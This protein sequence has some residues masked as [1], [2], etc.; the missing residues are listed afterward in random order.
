MSSTFNPQ[1]K[2]IGEILNH[3]VVIPSVA[4]I[5]EYLF[6]P[7]VTCFLGR[8]IYPDRIGLEKFMEYANCVN[9]VF[10]WSM[11]SKKGI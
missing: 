8:T 9:V 2:K 7:L 4:S 5:N 3:Y 1:F 10:V 11:H 6:I